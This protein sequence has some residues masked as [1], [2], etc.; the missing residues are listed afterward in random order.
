MAETD[1]VDLI[2]EHDAS[3]GVRHGG[4]AWCRANRASSVMNERRQRNKY[5][6][7]LTAGVGDND[8][9]GHQW[10]HVE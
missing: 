7:F 8:V 2:G 4:L 10:F 5:Q 3:N 9:G 1:N 6:R